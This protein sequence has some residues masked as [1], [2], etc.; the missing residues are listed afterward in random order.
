MPAMEPRSRTPAPLSAEQVRK[1][2]KLARLGLSEEQVELYR[3]QLGA[4]LAY[5]ERLRELDLADVEP[6]ANPVEESNR[7]RADE[8]SQGL[9]QQTLVEMAPA[10]AGSF[11]A[12]PRILGDAGGA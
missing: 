4:V 8:P 6:L 11:V 9:N 12:V 10:A 3:E 1:V 2:A 7:L 5:V